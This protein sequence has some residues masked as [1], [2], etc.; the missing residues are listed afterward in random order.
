MLN[1]H[2]SAPALGRLMGWGAATPP[3]LVL[4]DE[5]HTY[6]GVHGAQVALLLRRWRHSVRRPVTFAGL[7]ATL[8]D[9]A[10]FFAPADRARRNGHRLHR[11]QAGT[12]GSRRP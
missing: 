5:V 3:R 10:S 1:R 2:A 8:R 6:A 12:P 11:A 4:L 9:A 7:S